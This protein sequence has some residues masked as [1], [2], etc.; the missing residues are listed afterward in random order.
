MDITFGIPHA[1]S[2]SSP[3]DEN[4]DVLRILLDCLVRLNLAFLRTHAVPALYRS[5]VRYGRTLIWE[6]I[7]ALFTRIW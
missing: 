7:L 5:R 2:A 6:P 1:F 3:E 4:S